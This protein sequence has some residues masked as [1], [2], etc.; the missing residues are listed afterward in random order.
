MLVMFVTLLSVATMNA[1][2]FRL[3]ARAGFNAASIMNLPEATG[4]KNYFLPGFQ[5]GV[6]AQYM[7]TSQFGLESGLY[8]SLLGIKQKATVSGVSSTATYRSSYLQLPITA[9]YK[10][11]AGL[12]LSLYPQAG[13]YLGYGLGGEVKV[14]DTRYD[15][16]DDETNRLDAG[17]TF[18]FNVEHS[19]LVIGLG[20]DLGLLKLNKD[21]MSGTKDFKN[22]NIKV[23]VGYFFF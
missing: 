21:S 20:C 16:F 17:L 10:F 6:M 15:F 18:G 9:L 14:G 22:V 5:A 8:F 7:L 13:V 2:E 11:D 4:V 3:G 1:Q 19:N 23:T 12:G